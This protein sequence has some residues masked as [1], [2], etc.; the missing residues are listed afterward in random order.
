MFDAP[1]I[2]AAAKVAT[3]NNC[4]RS[5]RL[6]HLSDPVVCGGTAMKSAEPMTAFRER[7]SSACI[8]GIGVSG[9]RGSEGR[10]IGDGPGRW[11]SE[12]MSLHGDRRPDGGHGAVDRVRRAG[13]GRRDH[14]DRR[15]QTRR[16]AARSVPPL[17][18]DRRMGRWRRRTQVCA[19]SPAEIRAWRWPRRSTRPSLRIW[20]RRWVFIGSGTG[21]PKPCHRPSNPPPDHRCINSRK[22]TIDSAKGCQRSMSEVSRARAAPCA[23]SRLSTLR[24]RMDEPLR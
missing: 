5:R 1:P 7:D 19:L 22:R 11:G 24:A 10:G 12:G 4:Q 14:A 23:D 6:A 18:G 9:Q 20:R 2:G 21:P 8:S 16:A 13:R 15:H 3:P 17:Q